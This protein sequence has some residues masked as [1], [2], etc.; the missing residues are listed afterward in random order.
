MQL[1]GTRDAF[2]AHPHAVQLV[3][4]GPLALPR[5]TLCGETPGGKRRGFNLVACVVCCLEGKQSFARTYLS[6]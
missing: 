4:R 5:G 2:P 6:S 3:P 1:H